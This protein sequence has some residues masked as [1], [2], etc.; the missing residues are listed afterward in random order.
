MT[1]ADL[2]RYFAALARTTQ[3][4]IED[5]KLVVFVGVTKDDRVLVTHSPGCEATCKQQ[6]VCAATL[7]ED[8]ADILQTEADDLRESDRTVTEG[9][10][11]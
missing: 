5:L 11:S 7:Y 6:N 10:P 4:S 3:R 9:L 1:Q 2:E 8:M